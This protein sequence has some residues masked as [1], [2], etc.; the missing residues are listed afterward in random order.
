MRIDNWPLGKI[1]QLPDCVFGRRWPV[2]T[3][4]NIA[5]AATNQWMVEDPLPDRCVLWKIC[6]TNLGDVTDAAV[7][8][9]AIGNH[10]PAND[11]EFDAFP[12]LFPGNFDEPAFEGGIYLMRYSYPIIF[13]RMPIMTSGNRFVVQLQNRHAT[14]MIRCTII[15]EISSIPTEVPDWLISGPGG[16]L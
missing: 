11:A 16:N 4:Q 13:C 12:R 8:K 9:F 1:M 6:I 7:V 10:E 2:F 14:V 3:S 5:G 15:F